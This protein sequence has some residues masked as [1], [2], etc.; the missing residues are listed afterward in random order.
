LVIPIL[1]GGLIF[2]S[3]FAKAAGAEAKRYAVVASDRA[4]VLIFIILIN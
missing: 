2:I 3:P 1:D 4:V